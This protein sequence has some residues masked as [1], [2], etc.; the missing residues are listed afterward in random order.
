MQ[1]KQEFICKDLDE[2]MELAIAYFH[3]SSE[4]IFLNIIEENDD[5]MKVEALIDINLALEG[6]K[7]LETILQAMNVE[8]QLE[9]RVLNNE[10]EIYYNIHTNENPLLIGV[11]GKTL[12]ALQTLVRNLLQTYTKDMLVVNVDV[13][14]YREN[15]KHQL[16]V[17][18]TKTAKEVAKTKEKN[19]TTHAISARNSRRSIV[20]PGA[21]DKQSHNARQLARPNGLARRRWQ[22]L[23]HLHRR[24]KDACKQRPL[25][26]GGY[27]SL[28]YRQPIAE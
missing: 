14:S 19:E 25:P 24:K 17:L 23:L 8:Y 16:E 15:R 28:R 9:V 11:K 22:L 12:D 5:N 6:K 3:L 20:R 21:G 2:G 13:G 18:A 1:R 4:K 7:Y 10:Q 26:L 27:Q